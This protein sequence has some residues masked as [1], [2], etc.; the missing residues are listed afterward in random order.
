M[1]F[2]HLH[3]ASYARVLRALPG[4]EV[5]ASD[6]GYR[7]RP[8]GETGGPE[9]AAELGVAHVD[10]YDE[11]LDWRPDAVVVCAENARHRGLVERA[12]RAGAGVLCE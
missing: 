6:P 5:R 4:V 10:S 11:L 8:P 2:A 1:S 9:L 7:E 12:A 3:A